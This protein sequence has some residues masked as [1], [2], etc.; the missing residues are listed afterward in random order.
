MINKHVCHSQG[1]G[2]YVLQTN[3]KTYKDVPWVFLW[4]CLLVYL[5][6]R[7]TLCSPGRHVTHCLEQA[8]LKLTDS[9]LFCLQ[10]AR[11]PGVCSPPH[12]AYSKTITLQ[13]LSGSIGLYSIPNLW[14][15]CFLQDRQIS[16]PF[17]QISPIYSL[18]HAAAEGSC[19]KSVHLT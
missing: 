3:S 10:S 6:E 12:L 18:K 19:P 14:R 16:L 5:F 7:V 4:L 15:L 13:L 2:I 8:G 11:T 9:T 1:E 17:S